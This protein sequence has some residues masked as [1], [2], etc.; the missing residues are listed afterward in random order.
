MTKLGCIGYTGRGVRSL[1][2]IQSMRWE[3]RDVSFALFIKVSLCTLTS[4]TNPQT[5]LDV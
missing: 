5:R 1:G 3:W 4:I 2:N